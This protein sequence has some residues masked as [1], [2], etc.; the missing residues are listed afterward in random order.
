LS[1]PQDQ[2]PHSGRSRLWPPSG[3]PLKAKGQEKKKREKGRRRKKKGERKK[4]EA[5]KAEHK[6]KMLSIVRKIIETKTP[7]EVTITIYKANKENQIIIVKGK[8]GQYK[9]K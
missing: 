9:I 3:Q 7:K 5:K 1:N 8:L 6:K 2:W 4:S